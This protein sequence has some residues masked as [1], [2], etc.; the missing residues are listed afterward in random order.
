MDFY[1]VLERV[2]KLLQQH[3]RLSYRALKDQFELDN[4][5][6][7]LLQEELIDIQQVAR[8]QDGRMLVWT[9][10]PATPETNPPRRAGAETQFYTVLRAVMSLL[11][12]ERRLTYRELKHIFGLDSVLLEGIRAELTFKQL[13]RDEDSK[14]LVWTGET[15][16]I[17]PPEVSILPSPI[18]KTR[19]PSDGPTVPAE[20][21]STDALHDEPAVTTE[22][23][24]VAPQAE[25]RQVT[26]MFCDLVDST[27][28]S[29]QLD[30][31]DLRDVIRAYQQASAEVIQRFDGYIA[32]HLGDGLLIYFGWPKAHED[33]AQR[34][35]YAGLGIVEAIT[36]TLNPRL[37]Q[38]KGVQ[39]TIR[40]GVHTGPV[41]VGEMG[42]GGRH[43]NLA[44]GETVNIASRLEGLAAPN[45][46]VVS[47][48]TARLVERAFALEDLGLRE[49]KGVNE[50]MPV[51]RVDR[52]RELDH[53]AEDTATG[54]FEAL[55]GRDEEIGLLLRRWQQSKE[56][57][58]QVVLISGE[59]GGHCRFAGLYVKAKRAIFLKT[60]ISPWSSRCKR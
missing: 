16:S 24:R 25:R 27:K 49:L 53:D 43:E 18:T 19:T 41:V 21:M 11:R 26:V 6:F 34:A 50:P 54:G 32:Q 12:Q 37:E 5:R 56:G 52:L 42:G 3:G 20:A 14:G 30:P 55:V 36:T 17:L 44:T 2:I 8:D 57:F 51:F 40:L 38:E 33:D 4:D 10:S 1:E 9:G 28:L 48:V 60:S 13:A 29:Q 46:V 7:D 35:L 58:G 39:L 59:A 31:E 22:P 45:T 47:H 15:Q 23:T